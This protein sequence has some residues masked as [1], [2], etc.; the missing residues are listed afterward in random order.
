ME[1][2]H[3]TPDLK[4]IKRLAKVLKKESP[5]RHMHCLDDAAR[6]LYG[7]RHYHE[8]RVLAGRATAAAVPTVDP[9]KLYLRTL[10]EYYL[11]F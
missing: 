9:A 1:K 3:P 6:Q 4:R 8:A 7:V 11:D 5:R 10:Q 2:H